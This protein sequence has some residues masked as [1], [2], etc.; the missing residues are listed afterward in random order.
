MR[1]LLALQCD[2]T[3]QQLEGRLQVCLSFSGLAEGTVYAFVI[4][5]GT[6]YGAGLTLSED[7]ALRFTAT[8]PFTIPFTRNRRRIRARTL[9]RT[10]SSGVRAR[11]LNIFFPHGLAEGT[12][13][14]DLSLIHI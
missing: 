4:P 7:I 1:G 5:A 14:E 6:P 10:T 12:A 11:Q 13:S 3:T 9:R 8:L 2:H